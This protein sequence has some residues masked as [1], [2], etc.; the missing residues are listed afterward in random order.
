MAKKMRMVCLTAMFAA[1]LVGRAHA[2]EVSDLRKEV[3]QQYNALLKVQNQ[4]LE[5][6]AA[7]KKQGETVKK[8]ESTGGFTI[9]ETL[10]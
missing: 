5:I 9:P 7:Q 2:D 3:E 8:L 10:K 6:E 1:G 4:L